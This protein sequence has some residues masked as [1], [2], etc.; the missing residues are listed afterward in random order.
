MGVAV[1][2]A[3]KRNIREKRK[4]I[5]QNNITAWNITRL[6]RFLC[7]AFGTCDSEEIS[8]NRD[9]YLFTNLKRPYGKRLYYNNEA[10]LRYC[11]AL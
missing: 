8:M 11:S 7:R 6:H 1:R 5:S 4:T 9:N 10:I 2:I 3:R